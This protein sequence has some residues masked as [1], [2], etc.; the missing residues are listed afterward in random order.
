MNRVYIFRAEVNTFTIV[1]AEMYAVLLY[2]RK[3]TRGDVADASQRRCLVL[4]DCQ[5]ALIAIEGAWRRGRVTTGREGD[6][7]GML[8]EI[9]RRRAMLGT[10]VFLWVPSHRGI[11]PNS[12]ADAAAKA[13]LEQPVDAT[14]VAAVAEAVLTRPCMYAAHGDGDGVLALRD[15]RDCICRGVRACQE[16]GVRHAEQRHTARYRHGP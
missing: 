2:L 9:C 16:V 10:C 7:G 15:R 14:G 8:E 5:P 11:S 13:Y 3:M 6:R 4:A 1:D 12:M